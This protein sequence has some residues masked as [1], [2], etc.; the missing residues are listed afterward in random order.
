MTQ[1]VTPEGRLTPLGEA[2]GVDRELAMTLFRDMS[3]ARGLDREAV[4]LQR[5]GEL[6]LWLE[7]LGQEAA[8]V[9]SIRAL[10]PDDHVFPS[11][12]EHAAALCRGITP[13]QLLAQWRGVAHAGWEP[14]AHAFH[15]YT[16]VLG[17][18]TLHATGYAM[19]CILSGQ[20][21]VVA[22]Y[23][24]DGAASQGDVN[25]ALNWAAAR[26]LPVLFI[27]QNN[28]WAISTPNS[29]QSGSRL[30][31]RATG[32]GLRAWYVD[33]NDA[34]AVHAVT[35]AA[36]LSV[37]RGDGP[38]LVEAE[39]YRIGGHSTSDDPRRYRP[40]AELALWRARDPISRM[41]AFL[42]GQG[43]AQAWF[44][45]VDADA[46]EIAGQARAACA[47]MTDPD[48]G[49]LFGHVYAGHHPMMAAEK[50]AYDRFRAAVDSEIDP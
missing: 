44:D 49:D 31:Q 3:L 26:G 5:Q 37:R 15:F 47:A 8:Q 35:A 22:T 42:R 17:A 7:S 32:F 46:R 36:A 28:Q 27:C 45:Q 34:A 21:T 11:Y 30:Y 25:E 14:S 40:D 38:A 10:R 33:G 20:D 6:G 13:S 41:E 18:Q 39:T 16:L 23:F 50:A 48:L 12:R 29:R 9:G 1:F 2:H 24:G 19:G 4:A 43:V